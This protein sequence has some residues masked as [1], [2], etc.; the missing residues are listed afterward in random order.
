MDI[1]NVINLRT[2][3]LFKKYLLSIDIPSRRHVI[4]T[5]IK[6]MELSSDDMKTQVILWLNNLKNI[7]DIIDSKERKEQIRYDAFW[8]EFHTEL[9]KSKWLMSIIQ[10]FV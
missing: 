1:Q 5:C 9:L 4:E 7:N 6:H 2:T 3:I 10:L 8:D